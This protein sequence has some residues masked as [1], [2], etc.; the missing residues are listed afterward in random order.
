MK[1]EQRFFTKINH[2][3]HVYSVFLNERPKPPAIL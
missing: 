2:T 3:E 1:V